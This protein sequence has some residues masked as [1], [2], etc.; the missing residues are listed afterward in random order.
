MKGISGAHDRVFVVL[1]AVG[2][3]GGQKVT[4]AA[5]LPAVVGMAIIRGVALSTRRTPASCARKS[6]LFGYATR[7]PAALAQSIDEP[8][9]IA[10]LRCIGAE[11]ETQGLLQPWSTVGLGWV[12]SYGI[13]HARVARAASSGAVRPFSTMR[14][15]SRRGTVRACS[16]LKNGTQ[17][18]VERMISGSR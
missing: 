7:A 5:R 12:L 14:G 4:F 16:L 3:H 13:I 8:P 2:N 11:W 10:K 15:R 1:V 6:G 9:P 18:G 17:I